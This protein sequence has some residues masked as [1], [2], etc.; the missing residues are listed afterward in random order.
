MR[1]EA[2]DFEEPFFFE[3]VKRKNP[4]NM[5]M[6]HCHNHYEI[7]YLVNGERKYFIEN[8]IVDVKRGD[9]ILIPKEVLHKTT[10]IS[11]NDHERILINV[12]EKW[13]PEEVRACFD[14]YCLHIP[15]MHIEYI[16][17]VFSQIEREYKLSDKFSEMLIRQLLFEL[18][19]FLT[20]LDDSQTGNSS[21]GRQN[22][23]EKA[24]QYIC[25]NFHANLTLQTMAKEFSM[26]KEYFSLRFKQVTGFGFREYLNQVRVSNAVKLLSTTNLNI[27]EIAYQCGYNDSNYFATVFKKLKGTTP[28]K[29][30]NAHSVL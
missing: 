2:Q 6:S 5:R 27:T 21:D 23:M 1:N 8:R 22:T 16:E 14:R 15:T 10:S 18:L 7:Y 4:M 28:K 12:S 19:V 24:A 3:H 25:D 26:N 11:S 29:Y 13:I 20:R 30:Q 17:N 9:I